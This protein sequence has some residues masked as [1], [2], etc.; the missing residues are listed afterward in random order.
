MYILNEEENIKKILST[1]KNTIPL[2]ND[3]GINT[4]FIDKTL[5]KQDLLSLKEDVISQILNLDPRVKMADI[6]IEMD[7]D[8][9]HVVLTIKDLQIELD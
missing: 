9:D 2:A 6:E 4:E 5:S 8:S 3:A 1:G 7:E